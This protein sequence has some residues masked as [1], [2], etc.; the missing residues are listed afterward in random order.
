MDQHEREH[1]FLIGL[2]HKAANAEW[3]S[4]FALPADRRDHVR[5]TLKEELEVA[6]TVVLSTCNR[7]EVYAL[8][9][10]ALDDAFHDRLSGLVF[11]AATGAE[12]RP[13]VHRGRDAVFHLFR[14][15]SGLDSMI[16][17]ESEIL[18]Q[19]K[20]AFE[21]AMTEGKAPRTLSD[22]FRQ[23]LSVGKRVRSETQL[24]QGSVS[25]ASTAVKLAKKIV[26]RLD[27]KRVLLIGAGE[28]GVVVA[29]HLKDAPVKSLKILNRTA[30]KA[31]AVAA[32]MGGVGAGFEKKNDWLD[33]A[34]VVIVC[35]EAPEP[36]L[37]PDDMKKVSSRTRCI[38]DISIPRA[39]DPK[40]ADCD[41]VFSFDLD[42]L[43]RLVRQSEDE[44]QKNTGAAHEIVVEETHK[45]LALQ[46]LATWSPLVSTLRESLDAALAETLREAD[47]AEL[48]P[49]LKKLAAKMLARTMDGLKTSVRKSHDENELKNAYERYL[50]G[51]M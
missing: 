18:G 3:R 29:R 27:D 22:L 2:N 44:R 9:Q 41:G 16:L 50:R 7:T 37:G 40:I 39:V 30:E 43:D 6:G 34:D 45:F 20:H 13:Y 24:G 5:R 33:E 28:T 25:V 42:D 4:R 12:F 15:V 47:G 21:E 19:V 36:V 35:V 23:A 48:E 49:R 8:S 46:T 31:A 38:I 10:K 14:V 1:L 51:G 17:G 32:E 26:G 11:P